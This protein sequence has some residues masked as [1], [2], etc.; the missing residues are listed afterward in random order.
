MAM[1]I[2]FLGSGGAIPTPR[3]G[4]QCRVCVQAR[5]LGVPYSR[6]GPSVFVHGPDVL[7]DTPEEARLMLDRS[8]VRAVPACFYSHWHPD[9]VEGRRVFETMNADW[10]HWP[11][12]HARTTVYLPEQVAIDFRKWLGSWEQFQYLQ[13]F[14]VV[15]V[16]VLEDGETVERNGWLIRPF[17]VAEDYVYAFYFEGEG[18]RVLIAPD[19]LFGWKPPEFVRGVDLAVLPMGIT[20]YDV[21]SGE[22]LIPPEHPV[23]KSEATFLQTLDMVR[24]LEARRVTLTHIEEPYGLSYDDFLRLARNLQAEGLPVTFASDTLVI[25]PD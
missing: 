15:D 10:F 24:R 14:G 25:E 8:T 21:F 23:L 17:R 13:R 11:P 12:E 9:H 16:V 3:P 18:R 7:I 4:C 1:Q 5:D 20:E 19:E 22:R 2:E 6:M